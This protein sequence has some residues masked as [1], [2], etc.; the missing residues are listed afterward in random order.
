M[1]EINVKLWRNNREQ[2]WSVEINGK[3]YESVPIELIEELVE[4]ALI[5]AE[6]SLIKVLT[7]RPH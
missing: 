2:D 7:R 5:V 3:R 4:R 1:Q 6:E